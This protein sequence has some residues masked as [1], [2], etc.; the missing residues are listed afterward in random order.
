[1]SDTQECNGCDRLF[2]ASKGALSRYDNTTKVCSSCG[3]EEGMAQFV[4]SG[5]NINPQSIL[6]GAG[7]IDWLTLAGGEKA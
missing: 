2:D 7:K 5:Y 4:A 1:M 3:Q 6:L